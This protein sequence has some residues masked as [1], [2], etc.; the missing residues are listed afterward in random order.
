MIDDPGIRVGE[1][2]GRD[3]KL[4]KADRPSPF[5]KMNVEQFIDAGFGYQWEWSNADGGCVQTK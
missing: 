1:V 2:W 3:N 5:G 4:A